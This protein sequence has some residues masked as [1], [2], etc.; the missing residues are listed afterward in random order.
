MKKPEKAIRN[1][2]RKRSLSDPLLSDGKGTAENDPAIGKFL[3]KLMKLDKQIEAVYMKVLK[4]WNLTM[5]AFLA[6]ESFLNHPEGIE[7]ACLADDL[8]VQ[9]QLITILLNDFDKRGYIRKKEDRSDHRRKRI[10]LSKRGKVFA[11]DVHDRIKEMDLRAM[12]IFS[13]DELE[14]MID[15]YS[16]FYENLCKT[17]ITE[18]R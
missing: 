11:R 13:K 7:P 5:N 17:E 14:R 15:L 1:P 10:T 4:G 16:R 18:I 12:S 6:L 8:G 3:K 2:N 9:R